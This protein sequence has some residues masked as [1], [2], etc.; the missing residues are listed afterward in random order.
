MTMEG[1]GGW[2][3]LDRD[4]GILCCEYKFGGGVA[5]TFVFRAKDDGLVV[6]SPGAGLD[7]STIDAVKSYGKVTAL[8]ANN[9]WHW[10]GQETWRKHFPE[11]KSYAPAAALPR[12]AKKV[13]GVPFEPIENLAPLLAEGQSVVE[14][15][16]LAGNAFAFVHTKS[17]NYWYASDLLANIPRLPTNFI[18]KTLMSMTDSAPGYKLFRPAVWL[19]VKDKPAL[20]SWFDK[21]LANVPPT[22]VVPAHGGPMQA[23][24]LIEQTRAL[25]ARV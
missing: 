6:I 9:G 3:V 15:T 24:D 10:L 2:K 11:A 1:N 18:F 20:R 19:Q 12:I 25:I 7:P 16:G 23:P 4:A 8:V 5:T 21:E 13:P 22:T 17:G 14:P